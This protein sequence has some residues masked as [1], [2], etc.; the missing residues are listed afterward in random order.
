MNQR[1]LVFAPIATLSDLIARKEV[2]PREVGDAYL[3]RIKA[4]DGTLNCYIT[5]LEKETRQAALVAG[6]EI[7]RGHY[8]GPLHGIPVGVKDNLGVKGVRST[9]GSKLLTGFVPEHDAASVERLKAAGAIIIGKLNMHELAYGGTTINPYFG[10]THNPWNLDYTPGGSSGGSGAAVA[11]GLCAAALGTDGAGSIRYPAQACGIVGLKPTYGRVSR[12]GLVIAP[13]SSVDHTGPLTRTVKDCA[14]V[15]RVLAGHDDRDPGSARMP[16]PDFTA[17][18][19]GKVKGLRVGIP[20]EP[21]TTISREVDKAVR[22]A[23]GVLEGLGM[24]VEEVSLPHAKA[25]YTTAMESP[26]LMAEGHATRLR[27]L[28]KRYNASIKDVGSDI[29][30]RYLL[31]RVMPASFYI[32]AQK[33][34]RILIREFDE[35]LRKVDVIATPMKPVPG[36][37]LKEGSAGVINLDGKVVS[38]MPEMALGIVYNLT[39]MPALTLPCGF[40]Q[41]GVPIG[42][43]IAGRPFEEETVLRVAHAYEQATPWHE[44]HPPI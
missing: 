28:L 35:A 13:Q 9:A 22:E 11:A 8:R 4:I 5:L 29:V 33:A 12:Y 36:Q 25:E 40:A 32:D 34:R 16:V 19:N 41:A 31:A 38:G 3:N 21:Y 42:L 20:K 6:G 18:L 2:S 37:T 24:E 23:V 15:L 1:E 43:Q 17:G 14:I 44:K 39:G 26:I 7:A 10:A 27:D 30:V